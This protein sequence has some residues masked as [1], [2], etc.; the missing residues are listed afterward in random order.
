MTLP[1]NSADL[2]REGQPKKVRQ[3]VF[4]TYADQLR[5]GSL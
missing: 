1:L 3:V 4:N 5:E 2:S